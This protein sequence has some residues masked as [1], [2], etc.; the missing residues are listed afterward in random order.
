MPKLITAERRNNIAE[1]IISNGSIK[2]GEVAKKFDVSTETIR[3]DLIYLDKIGVIK[4]SRG[5]AL[6]SLE[7]IEKPLEYRNTENFDLK[8][9]IANKALS[10]VK[11]NSVIFIDAGST[12]LCLAKLLY[13]KK[14]LTIITNSFSAA[15]VLSNSQNIIHMSGGQ[16]NNTTMALEGFGAT[17]FLSKI[18]VDIA[19]LGSSGFKEHNGPTSIDFSDANVK[20]T[21]IDNSK[22]AV[23]LAD[24]NKSRSTALVEYT[25]WK[26]IDYLVTDDGMASIDADN[27]KKHVELIIITSFPQ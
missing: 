1:L 19:F 5:G 2:V 15:N 21:M 3:K 9:A 24:S 18:K 8:N 27:L 13:L 22:L 16:L 10:F 6:S 11:N 26:N 14:G 23:V 20:Q 17:N 12:T 4:K 7:I 25:S